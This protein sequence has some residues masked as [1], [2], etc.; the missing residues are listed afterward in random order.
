MNDL[1]FKLG[2]ISVKLDIYL[3]SGQ[4]LTIYCQSF[5]MTKLSGTKGGREITITKAKGNWS[6]DVDSI[7]AIIGKTVWF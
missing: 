6:V 5:E 3:N 7:N 2:I 4:T 1:L